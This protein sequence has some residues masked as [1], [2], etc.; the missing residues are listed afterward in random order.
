MNG[1]AKGTGFT[2]LPTDDG[3]LNRKYDSE[4][5]SWEFTVLTFFFIPTKKMDD[6]NK[7]NSTFS[8]YQNMNTHTFSNKVLFCVKP[9]LR[10]QSS[11]TRQN[12]T[13]SLQKVASALINIIHCLK[14]HFKNTLQQRTAAYLCV[15]RLSQ[16]SLAFHTESLK[17]SEGW[18][19]RSYFHFS[20]TSAPKAPL[21]IKRG[22]RLHVFYC[23]NTC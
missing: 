5:T 12:V 20:P 10:Q 4:E 8:Q 15:K 6:H 14:T 19:A 16:H 17:H 9:G 23:T 21:L 3:Q 22:K 1:F 18:R 7:Q 2:N 13:A 11:I